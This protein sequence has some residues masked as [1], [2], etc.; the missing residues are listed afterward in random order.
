[1]KKT[2]YTLFCFAFVIF[3]SSCEE[4]EV[5][6][7]V[8]VRVVD[9]DPC[10]GGVVLEILDE[11][12]SVDGIVRCGNGVQPRY[13]TVD[14]VPENLK[15]A[16]TKFTCQLEDREDDI[17]LCLAI[18]IRYEAATI[19]SICSQPEPAPVVADGN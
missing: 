19:S 15:Q 2:I 8:E 5:S 6:P 17:P 1:M 11:N 7:C 12:S 3:L 13:V 14:N 16:G 18:F 4:A 9:N 10:G